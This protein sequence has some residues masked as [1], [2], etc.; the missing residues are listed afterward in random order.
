MMIEYKRSAGKSGSGFSASYRVVCGGTLKR[1][2]GTITSPGFPSIYLQDKECIWKIQV[3]AG[4]SIALTFDTFD[5]ETDKDCSYD[6]IEIFDGIPFSSPMLQKLCGT[7][8][9]NPIWSTSNTMSLHFVNL[10]AIERKGFVAKFEKVIHADIDF[11][12]TS[13]HG[14]EHICENV[15]GNYIC[16]CRDGYKLLPDKSS[17]QLTRCGGTLKMEEGKITSPGFPEKYASG[18]N[19]TWI[20]EVPAGYSVALT[21]TDFEVTAN[22]VDLT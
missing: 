9:P 6:Y 19:C 5:L 16:R 21:F 8:L 7:D 11:C 17:C 13:N 2:K 18:L 14:C 15:P 1:D 20:V 12:A 10:G 3:P 4:F 22:I